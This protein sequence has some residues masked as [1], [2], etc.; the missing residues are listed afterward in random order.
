MKTYEEY[1]GDTYYIIQ[2][3]IVREYIEKNLIN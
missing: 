1:A 2:P 3:H